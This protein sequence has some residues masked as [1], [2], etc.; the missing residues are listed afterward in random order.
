M[1]DDAHFENVRYYLYYFHEITEIIF[2]MN[3]SL[4]F[5]VKYLYLNIAKLYLIK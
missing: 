3:Y 2:S 1:Y 5:E 4:N